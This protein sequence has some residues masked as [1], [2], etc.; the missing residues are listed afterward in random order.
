MRR[1]VGVDV[2][3]VGEPVGVASE[4]DV[5]LACGGSE[6]CER[7]ADR[8]GERDRLNGDRHLAGLDP[9]E[10]EHLVDQ[11]EQLVAGLE[12]LSDVLALARRES[13]YLQHLAKADDRVQRRAQLVAHPC[14]ELALGA[15][16]ALRPR[17]RL[18]QLEAFALGAALSGDVLD[19]AQIAARACSLLVRQGVHGALAPVAGDD[20]ALELERGVDG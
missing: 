13:F 10:V 1:A 6:E 9:G 7:V 18:E 5:A 19:C 2:P 3:V 17:G 12:D 16:R 15:V 8:V 4:A 11:R 20:P 14:Q